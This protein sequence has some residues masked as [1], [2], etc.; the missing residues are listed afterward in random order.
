MQ[1]PELAGTAEFL[2]LDERYALATYAGLSPAAATQEAVKLT[3]EHFR[4]RRSGVEGQEPR[5]ESSGDIHE[6]LEQNMAML[7][8]A[9]RQAL[10]GVPRPKKG[11]IKQVASW[12]MQDEQGQLLVDEA[13]R[14]L[15]ETRLASL[16]VPELVLV[17][18]V[19]DP[20]VETY[21][22]VIDNWR[23]AVERDQ[24]TGS[25]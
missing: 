10:A 14:Q 17:C 13:E 19:L 24:D 3:V 6:V 16:P 21:E 15:F 7:L 9:Q 8:K 20:R 12:L 1:H 23:A 18:D 2:S 4:E 5:P 11:L 22:Q 25:P